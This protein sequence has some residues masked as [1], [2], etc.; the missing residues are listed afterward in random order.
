MLI[1]IEKVL[2]FVSIF[3]SLYQIVMC[4]FALVK[5]K[6]KPKAINKEHKFMAVICAR[7]EEMVILNL[8]E[9]LKKQDYP[10]ELIDIYVVADNCS[11]NTATIANSAGAIALERFD[12]KKKSKGYALEW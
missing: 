12:K 8:I 7:N 1:G 11:D 9:S 4:F 6:E 5:E 3:F 10:K 2:F